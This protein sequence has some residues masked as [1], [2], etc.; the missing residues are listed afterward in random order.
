M[1]SIL[2]RH[3]AHGIESATAVSRVTLVHG[4]RQSGK[5]TLVRT[6]A[7]RK[8]LDYVT[9]DQRA[10]LEAALADP[11]GYLRARRR[12][13]VLDEVQR[14]GSELVLAIKEIVDQAPTPGQ[15]LLTGS[16][17]F[18]TLPT[19][20]ESLTG[21]VR[22]VRL[23][24][25]SLGERCGRPDDF[26]DRALTG[27][28]CLLAHRGPTPERDEY[29]ESACL[30]GFPGVTGLAGRDRDLWFDDYLDTLLQRE[31]AT[32]ADIRRWD[33]LSR[34]ARHLLARTGME[35]VVAR[36]A[37]ELEIDRST[38]EHH[39]A[40][41]ETA[42]L[43]QRVPA[44][45]RNPLVKTV[46][47]PKLYAADS[48]LAA[49]MLGKSVAALRMPTDPTTGAIL[50]TMV[51]GELLKQSTW[52]ASTVGVHHL[53]SADGREVDVVLEARDGSIVGLE[54]KSTTTPRS[55]DFRWL[56]D[57]RDRIDRAKGRFV[58]GVV[59]HTGTAR[60]PFGDRLVALPIA[61]LVG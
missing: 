36:I 32:A 46:H 44:W 27:P 13:L 57:L 10:E 25:F 59:M 26:L 58:A 38:V 39:L 18:L 34:L 50:E 29:L 49:S 11:A 60:L 6:I 23:H 35:L 52:S 15:F 42:F 31:I 9:F 30:G 1:I 12:P 48:G 4:P 41:L 28:D 37:A 33:I 43:V 17:N 45:G 56:K 55:E 3:A 47:R 61:D 20:S 53:R 5:S 7:A 21:R 54:V 8:G 22:I 40:W 16:T 51:V 24:P 2:E 19:L 14:A